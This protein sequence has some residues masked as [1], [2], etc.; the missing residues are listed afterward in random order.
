MRKEF[1]SKLQSIIEKLDP[2]FRAEGQRDIEAV[3]EAGA[4]SYNDLLAIL[5]N[6]NASKDIRTIVCWVLARLGNKRAISALLAVLEDKDP[7]L[8]TAAVR[9]L[10]ELGSKR[11]VR[12]L[13]TALHTDEDVEV[14]LAT[15]YA[16]GLLGDKRA[17][18]PLMT[19]LS[20]QNEEPKVR[21]ITAEALADL[22]DRR[23][24]TPLIVA[25]SDES[26]EVRFWAVFALGELGDSRALPELERLAAM[27]HAILPGWGP[28]NEEAAMAIQRIQDQMTIR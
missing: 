20:D 2:E 17:V 23:A 24:V 10:G 22:K 18:K 9:S 7:E 5:P 1:K 27:N 6:Q 8:R 15:A 25:L 11:A 28:V 21:G 26:I 14:R 16:L 12:P 19:K 4:T 3:L 13:I